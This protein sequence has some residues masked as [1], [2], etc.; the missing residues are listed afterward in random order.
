MEFTQSVYDDQKKMVFSLAWS[1]TND[2]V[3]W[4]DLVQEG[5]I[6]LHKA[7]EA[8]DEE[9]KVKFSTYAYQ[10]I[11]GQISQY[12][13]YN[14]DVVH[15]PISHCKR[16]VVT[17]I[18]YTIFDPDMPRD[19]YIDVVDALEQLD[20]QSRELI[21]MVYVKGMTKKQISQ[22]TGIHYETLKT[23]IRTAIQKMREIL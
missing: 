3:L 13:N 11:R 23:I 20:D 22:E 9:K 15:I 4:K 19:S 7:C 12:L 2:P 18:D 16:C 14:V 8:Y 6:G 1:F 10:K 5:F 17:E 21:H